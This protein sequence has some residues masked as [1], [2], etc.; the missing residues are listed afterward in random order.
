VDVG[1]ALLD[2]PGKALNKRSL[3]YVVAMNDE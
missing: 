2:A 1:E 3:R